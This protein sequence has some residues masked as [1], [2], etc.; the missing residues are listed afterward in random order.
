MSEQFEPQSESGSESE[1]AERLRWQL[2]RVASELVTNLG[3]H[4]AVASGEQV[5]SYVDKA[6]ESM[7]SEAVDTPVGVAFQTLAGV[8]KSLEALG[9][10]SSLGYCTEAEP[11]SPYYGSDTDTKT[12]S[13]RPVDHPR[14]R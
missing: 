9:V 10:T 6:L 1:F 14:P 7:P 13:H 2:E 12:C 11:P 4:G 8:F 5:R 3:L